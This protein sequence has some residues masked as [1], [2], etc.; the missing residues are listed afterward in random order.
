MSWFQDKI[1]KY[2]VKYDVIDDE[3]PPGIEIFEDSTETV[4]VELRKKE[5]TDG[6]TDITEHVSS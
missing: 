6:S 2:E 4:L 1:V 5:P 3:L